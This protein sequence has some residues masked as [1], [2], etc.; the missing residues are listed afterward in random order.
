MLEMLMQTEIHLIPGYQES[1]MTSHGGLDRR[2]RSH[3]IN[4]SSHGN[5]R[6]LYHHWDGVTVILGQ[7]VQDM[8]P[9]LSR[10]FLLSAAL[11]SYVSRTGI[12]SNMS[13][14]Y[15]MRDQSTIIQSF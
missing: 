3:P 1:G 7:D 6:Q 5:G 14:T 4:F 2:G 10:S 11:I 8:V 12:S 13:D 9:A 15:C